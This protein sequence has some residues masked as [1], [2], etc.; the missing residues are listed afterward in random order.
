MR[1]V[2]KA[3]KLARANGKAK[4]AAK[5]ATKRAAKRDED[6]DEDEKG[7]GGGDVRTAGNKLGEGKPEPKSKDGK[8][9]K[10]VFPEYDAEQLKILRR[11]LRKHWRNEDGLTHGWFGKWSFTDREAKIA[12]QIAKEVP[13]LQGK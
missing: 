5:V 1:K 2:T 11:Y 6:E 8:V 12:R 3:E 7:R 10:A 9:L 4:T 13:A